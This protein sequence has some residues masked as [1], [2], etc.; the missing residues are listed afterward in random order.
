MLYTM[1]KGASLRAWVALGMTMA[2]VPLAASAVTGYMTL[3]GG[4]VAAL[5]DIAMRQREEIDPTQRLRLLVW[6][7]GTPL[8]EYMDEGDPRRPAEYRAVRERVE[9]AFAT[10]HARTKRDP[11]LLKLVERWSRCSPSSPVSRSSDGSCRE[12]WSG[13]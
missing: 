2:I 12:V 8:D 5:Q 3:K 6:E 11:E 10:V 9:A 13:W 7:A 4:V 1:W